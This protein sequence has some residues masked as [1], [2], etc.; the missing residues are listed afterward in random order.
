[1]CVFVYMYIHT[2]YGFLSSLEFVCSLHCLSIIR[3]TLKYLCFRA[4]ISKRRRS[5]R[6]HSH[7]CIFKTVYT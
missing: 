4:E 2:N 3:V 5:R 7:T 1:M 6:G